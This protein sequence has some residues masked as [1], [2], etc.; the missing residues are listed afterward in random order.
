MNQ[1]NIIFFDHEPVRTALM[2]ITLTRPCS[3]IRVGITTIQEKW[4]SLLRASACSHL[5]P[6]LL[7]EA[8]PTRWSDDNLLV[9]GHVIPSATLA[10]QAARLEHGHMLTWQGNVIAAR[11]GRD[12]LQRTGTAPTTEAAERPEMVTELCH[13]FELNASMISRDFERLTRGLQSEPLPASNRVIGDPRLVFV[14]PGGVVEGATLNTTRGPIFVGHDAEIME[15][16]CIRGPFAACDKAVVRMGSKVY[17]G[18]TLGPWCKVGGEIENTVMM[19]FSNKAH[20]GFLGDAVVGQWCN[21]G[22][23]TSASNLRNDYGEVRQWSYCRH[24]FV[25]TGR[26]FVG[27]VIGDHS[28]IGITG[29]LNTGT[30]VGVGSNLYGSGFPSAFVP[31]FHKGNCQGLRRVDFDK[32]IATAQRMMLRRNEQ[33]TPAQVSLFQSLYAQDC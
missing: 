33:L 26:Q 16:C 11:G 20:E 1:I 6:Q 28:K 23:G 2:P 13:I 3:L 30:V 17:G 19:A 12:I 22:A 14:A 25:P 9:A 32:F 4:L 8:F 10:R 5:T 18:T 31:S 15:G 7:Q 27:A 24:D 21:I 29:M